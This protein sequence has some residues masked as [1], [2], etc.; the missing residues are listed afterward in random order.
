MLGSLIM[1]GKLQ[2]LD[3]FAGAGGFGLGFEMEGFDVTTAVE[4][5]A[6]ACDTLRF[7]RPQKHVLQGDIRDFSSAETIRKVV[8][9]APM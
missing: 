3:L 9:V 1:N 4:I 7:N 8:A 6:W 5:D 2:V